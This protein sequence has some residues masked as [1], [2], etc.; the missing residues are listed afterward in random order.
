[1]QLVD[2]AITNFFWTASLGQNVTDCRHVDKTTQD[3]ML[4]L[5]MSTKNKGFSF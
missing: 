5:T 4:M 2:R 1:M 3:E